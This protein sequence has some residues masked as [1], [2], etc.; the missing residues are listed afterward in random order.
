MDRDMPVAVREPG[1]LIKETRALAEMIAQVED[2]TRGFVSIIDSI[3]AGI[4][5]IDG[6][7][8]PEATA[9]R[10]GT[11]GNGAIPQHPAGI[12]GDISRGT[13]Q[14][15]ELTKRIAE[16]K[17]RCSAIVDRLARIA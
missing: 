5:P 1:E 6:G 8:W 9:E 13:D 7:P 11:T 2:A 4:D 10:A 16:H 3:N 14:L 15:Y 17:A 12:A